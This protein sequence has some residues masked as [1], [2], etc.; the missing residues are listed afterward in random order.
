MIRCLGLTMTF[1]TL[2]AVD[3][4][5]LEVAAGTVFGFLG[6]NGAG[7]TTSIRMMVGLL[8]PTAGTALL[9]GHDIRRDPEAAKAVTGYLPDRPHLHGKLTGLEH[10][11][12]VGGLYG[13]AGREARARA[14]ALL[15]ELG[16]AAQAGD[17]VET[18]SHGMKQRLALAGVLIH[19]P[20]ILILDEPMVGLDPEGA[21]EL[22]RRLR[23]LATDG[24]TIFLSTHSLAVAEEVSDRI[25]IVDR[26]RLVAA[27]TLAELRARGGGPEASLEDVFL[28]ILGVGAGAG[29]EAA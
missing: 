11:E 7:K 6:R 23:R 2:V 1:G 9:G 27:G 10:L 18:Y 4:L 26:G 17:L 29:G 21:R 25:G 13:L 20:R 28:D 15:D 24:T 8:A 14:G 16:L 12:F 22:R 3:R 19:R 5:D